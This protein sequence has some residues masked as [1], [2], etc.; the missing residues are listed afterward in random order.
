MGDL[1]GVVGDLLGW[2]MEAVVAAVVGAGGALLLLLLACC[3]CLCCR[4]RA[5]R[6]VSP[7]AESAVS[8]R[9]SFNSVRRVVPPAL[10][11]DSARSSEAEARVTPREG[12]GQGGGR[13]RGPGGRGPSSGS[14]SICT[15]PDEMTL[16]Q[17]LSGAPHERPTTQRMAS[18]S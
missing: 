2:P 7:G 8:A 10:P 11:G 1:L 18:A 17:S 12:R 16:V 5:R 3:C 9:R 6:K 13:G 14:P 15:G 4:R